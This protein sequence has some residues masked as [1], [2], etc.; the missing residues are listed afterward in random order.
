M[1]G[2]VPPFGTASH[3]KRIAFDA[4][5]WSYIAE[6]DEQAQLELL[7]DTANIRL[8]LQPSV[9]LELIRTSDHHKRTRIVSSLTSRLSRRALL[10]PD[11]AYE[12]LEFCAAANHHRPHWLRAFPKT[13]RLRALEKEWCRDLYDRI[14]TAP[15]AVA[16]HDRLFDVGELLADTQREN[17]QLAREMRFGFTEEPLGLIP[18]DAEPEALLGWNGDKLEAWRFGNALLWWH[19]LIVL[20]RRRRLAEKTKYLPSSPLYDWVHP[21]VMTDIV[22][23][24]REGWN[25]FWYYDVDRSELPRNWIRGVMQ[26]AQLERRIAPSNASDEQHCASLFDVDLFITADRRFHDILRTIREW[27]PLPM[28]TVGLIPG[29]TATCT[30]SVVS[31]ISNALGL[32]P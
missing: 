19:Q 2:Q 16:D 27:A 22:G 8:A 10:L 1:G 31:H 29:P 6:C 11:A 17:Q 23:G 18:D 7:E 26:F 4:N 21:R 32:L 9:V 20:P 28:A 15:D 30:P 5:V 13:E 14:R 24:D 12:A 3:V 25:R